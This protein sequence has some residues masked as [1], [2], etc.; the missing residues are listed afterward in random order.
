QARRYTDA[1]SRIPESHMRWFIRASMV[2]VAVGVVFAS[3]PRAAAPQ[4]PTY[5]DFLSPASPQDVTAAKKVDRIAWVDYKEG[6]RN[7]YTAAAPS[8]AP[9]NL[10][11]FTKDDGIDMSG[12]KISDDGSTVIFLRG[13]AP[14]RDGWS[15]NPSADPDGFEH[16]IWA[17][18]TN[19]VGGAWR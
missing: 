12:I 5:K 17:A 8:F 10:T 19:G 9:V 2:A 3:V 16:A 4:A 15:P 13:A 6:T 11:H 14:N 1:V 7:A 18:R